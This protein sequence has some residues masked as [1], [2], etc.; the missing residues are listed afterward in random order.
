M[1]PNKEVAPG[2]REKSENTDYKNGTADGDIAARQR[3]DG[4]IRP[5]QGQNGKKKERITEP[6]PKIPPG[7]RTGGGKESPGSVHQAMGRWL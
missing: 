7:S 6:K 1:P 2:K 5:E 3:A 4:G